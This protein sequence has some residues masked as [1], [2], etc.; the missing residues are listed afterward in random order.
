MLQYEYA[1]NI[2]KIP[3]NSINIMS[4]FMKWAQL[5]GGFLTWYKLKRIIK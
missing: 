4:I 3:I 1:D 5:K 2:A